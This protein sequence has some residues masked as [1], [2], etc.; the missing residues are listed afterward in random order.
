MDTTL[1][2]G[3]RFYTQLIDFQVFKYL[4]GMY[5]FEKME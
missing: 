3:L 2:N 1:I 5:R 4:N